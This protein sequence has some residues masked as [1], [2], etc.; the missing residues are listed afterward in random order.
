MATYTKHVL[1][2]STNGRPI[3]INAAVAS[4][5]TTI[6]TADTGTTTLDEIYIWVT[7]TATDNRI[8]TL[9]HGGLA[10]SDSSTFSVPPNDGLY[11]ISP[12][13]ILNNALISKMY[14]TASETLNAVGFVNR[15]A[16]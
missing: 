4:D 14:A 2:G 5:G 13:L 10:T 7:N 9:L 1:S 3:Q 6:H 8:V 15:I 12:G 16:T 11:L